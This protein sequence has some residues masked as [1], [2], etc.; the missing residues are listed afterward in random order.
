MGRTLHSAPPTALVVLSM[1]RPKD[2]PFFASWRH[3]LQRLLGHTA[4]RSVL[5]FGPWPASRVLV[6]P[7]GSIPASAIGIEVEDRHWTIAKSLSRR[8]GVTQVPYGGPAAQAS[9]PAMDGVPVEETLNL[10]ST[11]AAW[12]A[13]PR[14]DPQSLGR[15]ACSA[16]LK[17]SPK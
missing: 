1:P 7:T 11:R 5:L 6:R 4:D 12:E 2:L 16:V 3:A 14:T 15:L 10:R 8:S 17:A 9:L 13:R